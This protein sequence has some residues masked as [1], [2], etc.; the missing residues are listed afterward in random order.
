MIELSVVFNGPQATDDLL[1][2]NGYDDWLAATDDEIQTFRN[3][4][5]I[6]DCLVKR[7]IIY[8]KTQL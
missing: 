5:T 3:T 4:E 2:L 1:A 7:V 6:S 8:V